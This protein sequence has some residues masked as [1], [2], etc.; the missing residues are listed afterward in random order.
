MRGKHQ[1]KKHEYLFLLEELAR[2]EIF[3][4]FAD[5]RIKRKFHDVAN[6]RDK[7]NVLME[8]FENVEVCVIDN[9]ELQNFV[10]D[11]MVVFYNLDAIVFSEFVEHHHDMV[12]QR[13]NDLFLLLRL[14]ISFFFDVRKC[15]SFELF[16]ILDVKLIEIHCVCQQVLENLLEDIAGT[17]LVEG[18]RLCLVKVCVV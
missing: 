3:E 12:E 18:S 13:V 4:P 16:Q 10:N 9:R 5:P 7:Q 14:F 11:V 8:L 15:F 1:P 17:V 2:L 6:V